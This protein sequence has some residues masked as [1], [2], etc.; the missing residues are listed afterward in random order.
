MNPFGLAVFIGIGVFTAI[1]YVIVIVVV[2]K[3]IK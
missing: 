2:G 3:D 1:I